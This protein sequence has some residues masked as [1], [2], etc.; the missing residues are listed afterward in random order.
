MN[1]I[2]KLT[3]E[4]LEKYY[5]LKILYLQDNTI[6]EIEDEAF[7]NQNSLN[8]LDISINPLIE[9]PTMIFHLPS[10]MNL[11]LSQMNM[12]MNIAEIVEKSKPITSPLAHVDISLSEIDTLPDFGILP[13]LIKYNISGNNFQ[14]VRVRVSDLSGLCKLKI[15]DNQ[16]VSAI[17]DTECD[18]WNINNW[19]KVR[20]VKFAPFKCFIDE[21]C[22]I[23]NL[24]PT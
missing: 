22:K 1:R 20:G 24:L 9:I 13:S 8:T 6:A 4:D 10:L 12:N 21:A 11:Y 15:F 16:N 14:P 2:R 18:C 5:N 3:K 23:L 7:V 17:F 19:L